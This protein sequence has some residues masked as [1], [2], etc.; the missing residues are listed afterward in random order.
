MI[1]AFKKN[2]EVIKMQ[3]LKLKK[4]NF[5]GKKKN[6]DYIYFLRKYVPIYMNQSIQYNNKRFFYGS[7]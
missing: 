5:L 7:T 1:K 4:K 6:K 2:D 3:F